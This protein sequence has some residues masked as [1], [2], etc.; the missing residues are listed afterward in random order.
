MEIEIKD[1]KGLPNG[2]GN[3]PNNYQKFGEAS[4]RQ[5]NLTSQNQ[6]AT[7]VPIP[8][9]KNSDAK[10]N[11]ELEKKNLELEKKNLELEKKNLE[12]E[13]KNLELEKKN[14]D[15]EKISAEK[16]SE[17]VE[18]SEKISDAEKKSVEE[19]NFLTDEEVTNHTAQLWQNNPV[20]DELEPFETEPVK[21]FGDFK[22]FQ[23]FG[24]RVRGKKHK[25][26]GTNCDDWFEFD[27]VGGIIL[28]AV[29]DGAGSKKFSR[30]GA[31][32]S[33][34]ESVKFL[35]TE[36]KK[37]L[38]EQPDFVE[39]FFDSEDCRETDSAQKL[40]SI[41]Y[42]AVVTAHGKVSAAFT[43]R[44]DKPEYEK[45]L[46]RKIEFSDFASTLLLTI[47]I[48]SEKND[49]SV[50]A[51]YQIGDGAI[52][53]LD[54]NK[55]LKKIC[56]ADSGK[57]AGETEFLTSLN[58]KTK[59][60]VKMSQKNNFEIILSMTDG[61]ADDYEI[62]PQKLFD[63]LVEQKILSSESPAEKLA[64]WLDSYTIRGSF[65]DRTLVVIKKR[66]VDFG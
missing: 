15:T 2:Y 54:K 24:A 55:N 20:L 64:T 18:S 5:V 62:K 57:F 14:F 66:G 12:L 33:C 61:V 3:F 11:L 42:N 22:N 59:F 32:I 58:E 46:G 23:V 21:K 1:G 65:D 28:S 52:F 6:F 26:E 39:K 36:L 4:Y 35:K 30:I 31:K 63:D 56:E 38:Q 8:A 40:L 48:P 25:H 27:E 47:V 49:E 53:S 16:N 9:T 45:V 37:I 51:A 7:P 43:E 13:R 10:K 60:D 50:I 17:A 29:S 44:K 41:I 19:K 34:Q